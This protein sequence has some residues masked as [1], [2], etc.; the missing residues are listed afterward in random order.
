MMN[1]MMNKMKRKEKKNKKMK[2]E[3]KEEKMKIVNTMMGIMTIKFQSKVH[4][5]VHIS[6]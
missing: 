1:K 4:V 6:T 2:K 5:Y 3:E